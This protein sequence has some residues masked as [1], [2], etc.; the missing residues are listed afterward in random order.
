V[1]AG[2]AGDVSD[3]LG[4]QRVSTHDR[5][6]KHIG[7]RSSCHSEFT[8]GGRV[9]AGSPQSLS[10]NGGVHL[11]EQQLQC[12]SAAAVSRRWSSMRAGPS[13]HR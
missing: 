2:N 13:V 8:G 7:V 10:Q 9:D 12:A 6:R 5:G 3:V 11:V 4:R 1:V